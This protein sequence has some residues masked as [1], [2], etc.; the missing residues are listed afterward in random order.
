[1]KT[2]RAIFSHGTLKPIDPL[3]LPEDTRLTL[4]LVEADDLGA[5]AL[6]ELAAKDASFVFLSDPREDIYS[7]KDGESV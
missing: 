1:M 4:A 2:I 7:E 3:D 6:A 5:D